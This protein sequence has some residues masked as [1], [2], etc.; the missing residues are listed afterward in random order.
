MFNGT[1]KTLWLAEEKRTLII[2]TLT[3][4]IRVST[5]R[6]GIQFTEFQSMMSKVQHAFITIPAGKGLLSP[7]YAL[8][9]L[10]PKFVFLHCN[11]ALLHAIRDCRTFLRDSVDTPN[12]C[13]SLVTA[14]PDNIGITDVS[15]SGL[16][17]VILGENMGVT[18]TVFRL[19]WPK[20]ISNNIISDSNPNGAITNSDLEMAG[21]LMLWLVMESI[22]PA[23]ENAH[24]ALFSDNSPTVHWVQR[25]AA[26]HSKIAIQLVRAL[27]L[28]LQ[29]AKASPL[30]PLHIA[31]V[32]N[33]MTDIP[34][35]S[36]GSE[37]KWYC[38]TNTDLLTL[39]NSTFLLPNQASWTVLRTNGDDY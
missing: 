13:R 4:W 36:F 7:F 9:A 33:S 17:G 16:G 11:D 12:A 31:G 22:C 20:D 29:L 2:N 25:L 39:F 15:G 23:L 27:A 24:V 38:K 10:Q 37:P 5:N 30:T 1:D 8:L 28:R 6:G 32:D 3:K 26:K 19:E 14:W 18:P 21:L 35:Q 34:S